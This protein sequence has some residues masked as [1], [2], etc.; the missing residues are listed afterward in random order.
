MS[1]AWELVENNLVT[2]EVRQN[3]ATMRRNHLELVKLESNTI[4]SL[5]D[6]K[7]FTAKYAVAML[8]CVTLL[9]NYVIT[10]TTIGDPE[11]RLRELSIDMSIIHFCI[12]CLTPMNMKLGVTQSDAWQEEKFKMQQMW[13]KMSKKEKILIQDRPN[14]PPRHKRYE[15]MSVEDEFSLFK[16]FETPGVKVGDEELVNMILDIFQQSIGKWRPNDT[17]SIQYLWVDK[18]PILCQKIRKITNTR[19]LNQQIE[20]EY[21]FIDIFVREIFR[22]IRGSKIDLTRRYHNLMSNTETLLQT[23][24]DVGNVTNWTRNHDSW[25]TTVKQL[26]LDVLPVGEKVIPP[27]WTKIYEKHRNARFS[28]MR[29]LFEFAGC[30]QTYG[31]IHCNFCGKELRKAETLCFTI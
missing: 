21:C 16:I 7:Y 2:W 13:I 4:L 12:V 31:S 9:K 3:A 27:E 17:V 29:A 1:L 28:L 23:N 19:Y 18:K 11:A 6:N 20:M 15:F 30:L 10:K 5:Q 24:R 22:R 8:R 26:L 25:M 14:A